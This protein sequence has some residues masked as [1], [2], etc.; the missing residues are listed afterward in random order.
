V[1]DVKVINTP[2]TLRSFSITVTTTGANVTDLFTNIKLRVGSLTYSASQIGLPGE[3]GTN[4]TIVFSN[5]IMPLSADTYVPITILAD[6]S[7][8]IGNSL[9][10]ATATTSINAWGTP[11]WDTQ[12]RHTPDIEDVSNDLISVE[13]T[14]LYSSVLVFSGA[15][16]TLSNLSTSLGTPVTNE[17]GFTVQQFSFMFSLTAGNEPIYVS[18]D[19]T[20][21]VSIRPIDSIGSLQWTSIIDN[22]SAEDSAGYFFIAPGTTKTF[23][24][25]YMTVGNPGTVNGILELYSINYGTSADNLTEHV[26]DYGLQSLQAILSF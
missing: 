16:A 21:A 9:D 20:M 3:D 18:S 2:S 23:T 7:Q 25:N 26:I 11:N 17:G 6:V 10:G 4:V 8:D 24:V 5:I 13:E 19:P 14:Y 12:Y 15:D 22:S 1:Y